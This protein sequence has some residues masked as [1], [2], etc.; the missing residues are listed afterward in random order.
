VCF[1]TGG[2]LEKADSICGAILAKA[3]QPYFSPMGA[4]CKAEDTGGLAPGKDI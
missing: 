4:L 1:E 2:M 3:L